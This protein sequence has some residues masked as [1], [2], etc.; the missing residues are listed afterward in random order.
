MWDGLCFLGHEVAENRSI[1]KSKCQKTFV[2]T[3]YRFSYGTSI[4]VLWFMQSKVI[5]LLSIFHSCSFLVVLQVEVN[6]RAC[7]GG[8][9]LAK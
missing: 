9:G 8:K 3:T 7:R 1:G 6:R 5:Y 2:L 4:F